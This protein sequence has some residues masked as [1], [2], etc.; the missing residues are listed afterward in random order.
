MNFLKVAL[1]ISCGDCPAVYRSVHPLDWQFTCENGA[2][3]SWNS[4]AISP[5]ALLEFIWET[6]ANN[7]TWIKNSAIKL[8]MEMEQ[9]DLLSLWYDVKI[10]CFM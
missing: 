6:N 9:A 1:N 4:H 7:L 2:V 5:G 10:C 8:V 3:W